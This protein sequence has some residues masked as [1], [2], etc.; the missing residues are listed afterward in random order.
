MFE[1]TIRC[2]IRDDSIRESWVAPTVEK[3]MKS[4]PTRFG[5]WVKG[6]P[7]GRGKGRARKTICETFTKY[8]E[9]NDLVI[10]MNYDIK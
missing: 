4:R 8:L 6:N 10:R 1:N 7:Y 9:A 5:L 3:M 2:R